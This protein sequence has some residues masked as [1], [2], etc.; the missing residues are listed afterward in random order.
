M[1]VPKKKP[2]P[3]QE[4]SP[5]DCCESGCMPCVYDLYEDELKEYEE[6]LENWEMANRNPYS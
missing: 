3:P 1:N 2:Q 5:G 4:P 6:A